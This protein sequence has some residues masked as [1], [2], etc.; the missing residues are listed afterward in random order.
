MALEMLG[1][2]VR[3]V[4]TIKDVQRPPIAVNVKTVCFVVM[5]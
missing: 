1:V 2:D 4:Y 3:N 5:F